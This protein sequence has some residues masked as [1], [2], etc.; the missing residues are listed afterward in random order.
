MSGTEISMRGQG[1]RQEDGSLRQARLPHL[2]LQNMGKMTAAPLDLHRMKALQCSCSQQEHTDGLQSTPFIELPGRGQILHCTPAC[3]NVTSSL[4]EASFCYKVERAE[5]NA[6][7]FSLLLAHTKT[8]IY[9]ELVPKTVTKRE[10]LLFSAF[11]DITMAATVRWKENTCA[12]SMK[13]SIGSRATPKQL[14]ADTS[15]H[16]AHL[17]LP[18]R[19]QAHSIPLWEKVAEADLG[20]CGDVHICGDT[21]FG[22]DPQQCSQ[23]VPFLFLRNQIYMN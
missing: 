10:W 23:V 14:C 6:F 3:G 8:L 17:A 7:F 22:Y 9:P 1:E 19:I 5:C 12:A 15:G 4:L 16:V 21:G 20:E 18:W 13:L 2:T 11:I